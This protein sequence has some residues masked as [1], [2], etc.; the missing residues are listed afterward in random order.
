ML[1]RCGCPWSPDAAA[2]RGLAVYDCNQATGRT[3][4]AK[5]SDALQHTSQHTPVPITN[6]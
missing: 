6:Q 4:T 2:V 1:G 3:N 5:L